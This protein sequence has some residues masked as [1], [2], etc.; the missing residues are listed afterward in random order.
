MSYTMTVQTVVAVEG[1][2]LTGTASANAEAIDKRSVELEEAAT[3]VEIFQNLDVSEVKGLVLLCSADATLKTNSSTDPDDTISLSAGRSITWLTG[4]GS[5]PL[6]EDVTSIFASCA[7]G[8]TLQM[9]F[10]SDPTP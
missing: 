3:D 2:S 7:D 5:I 9:W 8:G 10:L 6:T 1:Q 4:Q